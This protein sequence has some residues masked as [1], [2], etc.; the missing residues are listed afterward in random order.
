MMFKNALAAAIAVAS[1]FTT[2]F[3]APLE[4]RATPALQS[5]LN[6]PS[7]FYRAVYHGKEV[8]QAKAIYPIGK[9]PVPRAEGAPIPGDLGLGALY[10]YADEMEAYSH[11]NAWCKARAPGAPP[12][13]Y[14]VKFQYTPNPR[15]KPTSFLTDNDAWHKFV[16]ANN[17]GKG[18]SAIKLVEAPLS[19]GSG[20]GRRGAVVDGHYV[21]QAGFI[22]PEALG[23]LKVVAVT[24]MRPQPK[25]KNRKCCEHC[26]V[27]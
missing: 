2:T 18:N 19:H 26:N 14:L 24:Q 15:V 4:R 8:T 12:Y 3:A 20:K 11:G 17:A 21:Y 16:D 25:P 6:R 22:G 23:T 1:V 9:S 27:M 13:W 10:V 7:T 5:H